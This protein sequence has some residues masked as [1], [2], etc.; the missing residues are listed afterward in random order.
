VY[1]CNRQSRLSHWEELYLKIHAQHVQALV[2][3][4][5]QYE[6]AQ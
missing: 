1:A 4:A 5:I 6:A 2:I 3:A